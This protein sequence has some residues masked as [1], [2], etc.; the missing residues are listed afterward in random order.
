MKKRLEFNE[1]TN[2]FIRREE[3]EVGDADSIENIRLAL[4][5]ELA[6][7]V[8]QVKG[9]KKR[10]GEIQEMLLLLDE[11]EGFKQETGG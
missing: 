7:I 2:K 1:K 5:I 6:E 4:K 9:L 10:A 3:I 8:R 11:K